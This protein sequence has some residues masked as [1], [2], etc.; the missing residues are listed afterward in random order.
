VASTKP[1]RPAIAGL[2]ASWSQIAS[3]LFDRLAKSRDKASVITLQILENSDASK[4]ERAVQRFVAS[5]YASSFRPAREVA[6]GTR[7]SGR[8]LSRADEPPP[9]ALEP[10][11]AVVERR[12]RT[13]SGLTE[14]DSSDLDR[15]GYCE[16][17]LA[18][19]RATARSLVT[20]RDHLI[21]LGL[22][23]RRTAKKP[24]PVVDV[25]AG[26]PES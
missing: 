20:R 1:R 7:R 4:R 16:G 15:A 24:E 5:D 9:A 11:E 14:V 19:W 6:T 17:W 12:W 3:L 8:A 2:H 23:E 13:R 22:A 18:D 10:H 21:R 25:S 26:D